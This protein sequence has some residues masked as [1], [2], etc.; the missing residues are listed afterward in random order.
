MS[1]NP[2]EPE[3][4]AKCGDQVQRVCVGC[5]LPEEECD[6]SEQAEAE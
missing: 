2:A 3:T 1:Q 5:E 6:C 4:C